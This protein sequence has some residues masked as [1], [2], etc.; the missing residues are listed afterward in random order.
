MNSAIR[1]LP[2]AATA[3]MLAL[4][5][6]GTA[7]AVER[8]PVRAEQQ[9]SWLAGRLAADMRAT[10]MFST[11]EIAEP[12]SLVSSLTDEQVV[13][14]VR[15]YVLTREMA[16]RDVRL[17]V[18]DSSETLVRLRRA[19]RRAY[20]ELAAVSSG[21]R[22]LCE[23]AYASIPGWCLRYRH[24]VPDWYYR[25][26]CYVG[27]L[28]SARF[29]GA[30]SVRAYGTHHDRVSRHYG[31]GGRANFGGDIGRFPKGSD[32]IRHRRATAAKKHAHA[33]TKH[34]MARAS[35]HGPASKAKH[36]GRTGTA[37]HH[38]S[39]KGRHVAARS[40]KHGPPKAGHRSPAAAAK[41]G[42]HPKTS[43]VRAPSPK[44]RHVGPRSKPSP[45][46][47]PH[48]QQRKPAAH[49]P[50][51]KAGGHAQHAA[52]AQKRHKS[53]HGRHK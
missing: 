20:W 50:K 22:T 9:R 48:R 13:L 40:A 29:G 53:G 11:S 10:G 35:K 39:H 24:A 15:L 6:A 12:L 4:V 36:G 44:A 31:R 19:I 33:K 21:C 26:G 47:Q 34:G 41:H 18:V 46:S 27:P 8:P 5:L 37:K 7:L 3:I 2:R 30:Y 17:V 25:E 45:H 16:E 43:R 42:K 23:F 49:A 28:V 38:G 32:G 14:L 51:G 52:H 1:T